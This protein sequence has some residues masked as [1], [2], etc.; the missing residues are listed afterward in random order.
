M[1]MQWHNHHHSFIHSWVPP[2]IFFFESNTSSRQG[3][4]NLPICMAKTHLS[5][6]ADPSKKG[7]P[8]GFV[9]PI[10]DV[11]ASVGAG[12][13]YPLVGTMSTM[14]GTLPHPYLTSLL[15]IFPFSHTWSRNNNNTLYCIIL[16]Y[17]IGLPTRPVFY[18]IDV[19]PES[20]KI[21]G[22]SWRV[23]SLRLGEILNDKSNTHICVVFLEVLSHRCPLAI[24]LFGCQLWFS[25]KHCKSSTIVCA[26]GTW[27][28]W[29]QLKV[30]AVLWLHHRTSVITQSWGNVSIHPPEHVSLARQ[31]HH[32]KKEFLMP[33]HCMYACLQNN[34]RLLHPKTPL[35]VCSTRRWL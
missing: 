25:W 19:D 1:R 28:S 30:D 16:F 12:F 26:I 33:F 31:E 14:P 11:R 20:G 22:L 10:R 34:Y 7:A 4:G 8:T 9:I 15:F 23:A 5:L 2:Y 35:F 17:I 32:Q 29:A 3:F 24:N 21:Y 27:W 13:I 6:S 18:D